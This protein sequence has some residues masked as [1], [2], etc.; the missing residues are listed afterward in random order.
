MDFHFSNFYQDASNQFFS[1]NQ[2]ELM[3]KRRQRR[4]EKLQFLATGNQIKCGAYPIYGAD[5]VCALHML[6]ETPCSTMAWSAGYVHCAH[7]SK[8]LHHPSTYWQRTDA[9]SN[10]IYTNEDYVNSLN[11]IFGRYEVTP[12]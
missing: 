3:E 10:L 1:P 5:L 9:L 2:P 4:R 8:A 12:C 11:D 6:G 7:E